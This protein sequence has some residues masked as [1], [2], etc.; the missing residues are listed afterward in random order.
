MEDA[1]HGDLTTE[2]LPLA[3]TDLLVSFAIQRRVLRGHA[4]QRPIRAPS[5][6]FGV[7]TGSC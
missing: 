2:S 3:G 6:A 1:P 4:A 7:G 5:H